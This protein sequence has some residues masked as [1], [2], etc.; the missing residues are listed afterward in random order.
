MADSVLGKLG[1]SITG[2]VNKAYILFPLSKSQ[3]KTKNK[4]TYAREVQ[5]LAALAQKLKDRK[6]GSIS[7]SVLGGDDLDF[8]RTTR[9]NGYIPF[10][11]QYNP[12]TLTFYGRAG[13]IRND[14]IGGSEIG[15][16]Q[17]Y[18]MPEET[19]LSVE[20]EFDDTNLTDAFMM[21][22]SS[23]S[24]GGA[25]GAVKQ[26]VSSKECSV[27]GISELFVS[28]IFSQHTRLVAFVWNNTIFWGEMTSADVS[29]TMFNKKGNPIRSKVSIQIRQ[30]KLTSYATE[31]SWEKAYKNLFDAKS[32]KS[33]FG[34]DNK[35][36]NIF[37]LQ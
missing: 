30:D 21:D 2:N 27:Q 11:V 4:D 7:T 29:Y 6:Q 3:D 25:A 31:E 14:T 35:A 9:D 5:N 36:S 37:N 1:R 33:V 19:I 28:A 16:Y 18:T 12:S 34:I 20:L 13:E 24:I 17:Q 8:A 22:A 32:G 23:A 15:R 26:M 10:R